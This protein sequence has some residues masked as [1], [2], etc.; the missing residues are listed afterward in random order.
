MLPFGRSINGILRDGTVR[1]SRADAEQ[2]AR[3]YFERSPGVV[4]W[5]AET[6]RKAAEQGYIETPL[7]RKR[8]FHN[9]MSDLR[10]QEEIGRQAVNFLPQSTASD[11]TLLSVIRLQE[12]GLDPRI[13]VHDDV[14]CEVDEENAEELHELQKEI[15]VKCGEE[16]FGTKVPFKVE[17]S[18]G[19]TWGDLE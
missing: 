18:I 10:I 15:M 8:R 5:I 16:L 14:I 9:P 17:G 12:A 6:K 4:R 7:G 19:K 11:I 13:T 1:L 2:I 3:E